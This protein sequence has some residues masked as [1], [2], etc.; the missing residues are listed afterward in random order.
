MTLF[1]DSKGILLVAVI[2]NLPLGCGSN[3][4]KLLKAPEKITQKE[5]RAFL[6]IYRTSARVGRS[7]ESSATIGKASF[8]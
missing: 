2:L 5:Q 4:D 3:L 7:Q 8:L 1:H 6:S